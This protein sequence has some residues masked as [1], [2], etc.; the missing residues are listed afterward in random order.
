MSALQGDITT[1]M[2]LAD[3]NN[4]AALIGILLSNNHKVPVIKESCQQTAYNTA[5]M[6]CANN[7]NHALLAT[8]HV[9]PISDDSKATAI[10]YAV[11]RGDLPMVKAITGSQPFYF[12]AFYTV[13]AMA[14]NHAEMALY[15]CRGNMPGKPK[16]FEA[17]LRDIFSYDNHSA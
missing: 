16:H 2:A 17:M 14:Q 1:T 13:Q 4:E 9:H 12:S 5:F 6:L 7:G 15:L 3:N 11:K 10:S 8:L